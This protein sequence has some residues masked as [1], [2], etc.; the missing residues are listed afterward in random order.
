MYLFFTIFRTWWTPC[1]LALLTLCLLSF[2]AKATHIRAG[3]IQYQHLSGNTYEIIVRG[4]GDQESAVLFGSN[5]ILDFG[6]G[7]SL[8]ISNEGNAMERRAITNETWLYELKVQHTFPS[9]RT[10]TISYREL[11]RN[12]GVLNISNSV[13]MPFYIES[14]LLHDSFIGPNNSPQLKRPPLD[15]TVVGTTYHHQPGATDT[16]GDSLAYRLVYSLQD[17]NHPVSNYRYPH[18]TFPDGDSRNGTNESGGA[19]YL[20]INPYTGDV[21]WDAPGYVGEYNL[22]LVVEEWRKVDGKLYMVGSVM[23]DM[24][25]L[26]GPTEETLELQF[27]FSSTS[28]APAEGEAVQW[29]ITATALSSSDSVVLEI[30]GD[31]AERSDAQLSSR[32][33]KGKGQASV[34]I[35]WNG[36]ADIEQHY[37][38]IAR[39]YNPQAPELIRARSVYIYESQ[40]PPPPLGV[41]ENSNLPIQVYPNPLQ[42]NV[43]Y[44]TLP[45][46]Q[47]MEIA[48][49][50]YDTKGIRIL[51]KTSVLKSSQHPVFLNKTTPGLYI[52]HLYHNGR[53][54]KSKVMVQ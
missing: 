44:F 26:V 47:G 22:A 31:F 18:K 20:S 12:E 33:V 9:A 25:V 38:L 4:Y 48:I 23:R 42:G 50:L 6:D 11:Y 14:T 53:L 3:E 54:Y 7:T 46:A 2:N 52:L 21:V 17:T 49:E 45:E 13:L 43:F 51:Q 19:P 16:D 1:C 34:T 40:S 39:S 8:Q 37:Q 15:K 29:T 27:P 35:N 5:G 24:Q 41:S 28:I 36:E 30:W 32:Q 10:Y